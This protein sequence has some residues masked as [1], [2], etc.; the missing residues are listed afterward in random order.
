MITIGNNDFDQYK[1]ELNI[2]KQEMDNSDHLKNVVAQIVPSD[3]QFIDFI[4]PW[5]KFKF[6]DL[7]N[8]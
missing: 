5:D 7:S 4:K 3:L 8:Y 6:I 1:G 2:V